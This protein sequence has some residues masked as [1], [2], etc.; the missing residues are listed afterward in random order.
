MF[1]RRDPHIPERSIHGLGTT[2][3]MYLLECSCGWA[4]QDYNAREVELTWGDHLNQHKVLLEAQLQEIGREFQA[5]FGG[6]H[7]G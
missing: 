3:E 4:V 1:F 6:V 2:N 7:V 5:E